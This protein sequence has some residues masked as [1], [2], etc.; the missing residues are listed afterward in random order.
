MRERVSVGLIFGMLKVTLWLL[1]VCR[2]F[3]DSRESWTIRDLSSLRTNQNLRVRSYV[4]CLSIC[5][6]DLGVVVTVA[7]VVAVIVDLDLIKI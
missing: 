4:F 1:A 5:L 3:S 7:V 2:V 6:P